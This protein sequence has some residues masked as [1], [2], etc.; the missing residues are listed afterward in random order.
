MSRMQD[1]WSSSHLSGGNM[2]YVDALY[3]DYCQDP[4]SVP[5]DWQKIFKEFKQANSQDVSTR[6]VVEYF[7]QLAA[8]KSHAIY[9]NAP[10]EASAKQAQVTDLIY[11]FRAYGHL[12]ANLNPLTKRQFHKCHV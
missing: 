4:Q 1:L 11:A 2:E 10:G 8:N 6:E 9:V 7:K 12:M 5:A 3:D